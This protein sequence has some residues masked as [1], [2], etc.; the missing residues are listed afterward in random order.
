MIMVTRLNGS[1]YWINPHHIEIIEC[2]PDVTLRM[3][4]GKYYVVKETPDQLV[5]AI[6]AYRR[7]I[8]VFK[9]DL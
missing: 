5:E 4:S 6:I 3:I 1:K 2:N 9:N 8:G 7:C